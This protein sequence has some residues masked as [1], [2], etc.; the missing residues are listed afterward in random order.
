[1]EL[2]AVG[3]ILPAFQEF[4]EVI[5]PFLTIRLVQ[6][7]LE[8]LLKPSFL[9]GSSLYIKARIT[10]DFDGRIGFCCLLDVGSQIVVVHHQDVQ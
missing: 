6:V 3:D 4:L 8:F 10:E 9:L 7:G 2:D 1:M 5:A